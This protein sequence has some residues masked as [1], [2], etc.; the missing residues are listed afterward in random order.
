MAFIK[1][2]GVSIRAISAAVPRQ[3]MDN[4]SNPFFSEKDAKGIIQLT[5]IASRRVAG[6]S[7]CSSDLCYVAAKHLMES[8]GVSKD[9]ID[10]L[11]FVSQT[12][13]YR[14]PATA[15]ILQDRLALPKTCAAFDVNLGCSGF[16]YGLS[17]AY[18]YVSME[19]IRNVLL[20]NG[21][22][23]TKVFSLQ[24]RST[25][26]LFGDAGSACLVGKTKKSETSFFDLNSD[27]SRHDMVMIKAGGY[28]YPSSKET[29]EKKL[30]ED[31]SIRSDEQCFMNAEGIFDF[32]MRDVPPAIVSLLTR[33]SISP[34]DIDYFVLHQANKFLT[35]RIAKKIGA[36]AEKVPYCL[37]EFGNTSSVS[38]PLTIVSQLSGAFEG[39]RKKVL[40]AGF[41][42]GLSWGSC[43]VD[44]DC[45]EV[46]PL[47]E[48]GE[49]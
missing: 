48:T 25:S 21:E 35:D 9:S 37:S 20:L 32:T 30:R 39:M 4:L 23:R 26:L 44:F 3:K 16:V 10:V 18:S 33:T 41:G 42:V 8:T 36:K 1:Y 12:P 47:I 13:D 15:I 24:D 31:G 28:R 38:I 19:G 6:E 40:M 14:Q 11:V 34:E 45:T 22:T 17:I 29:I 7:T 2:N 46:L 43:I 49:E 5:G 27:G